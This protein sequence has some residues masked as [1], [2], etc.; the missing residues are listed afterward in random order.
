MGKNHFADS[1]VT[2][3][4]KLGGIGQNL[5]KSGN[6]VLGDELKEFEI[7][8]INKEQ[9]IPDVPE[10]QVNPPLGTPSFSCN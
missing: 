5:E 10:A 1:G 9:S 2:Q 6:S 3:K 8:N 7:E 4:K